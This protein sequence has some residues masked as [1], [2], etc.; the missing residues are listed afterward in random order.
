MERSWSLKVKH[1]SLTSPSSCSSRSP[2]SFTALSSLAT[3][4]LK[5]VLPAMRAQSSWNCAVLTLSVS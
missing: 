4:F 3:S 2:A 5:R 1:S